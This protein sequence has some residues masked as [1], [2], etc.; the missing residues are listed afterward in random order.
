MYLSKSVGVFVGSAVL[1]LEKSFVSRWQLS[2]AV[3]W[4]RL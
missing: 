3:K 1:A 4:V 2:G